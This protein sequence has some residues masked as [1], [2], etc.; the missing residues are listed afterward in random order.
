MELEIESLPKSRVKIKIKIK[1]EEFLNYKEKALEEFRNHIEI[2][3]FRKGKAPLDLIRK[4]IEP[5]QLDSKALEIAINDSLFLAIREKNLIPLENPKIKILKFSPS[6]PKEDFALEY[7]AEFDVLPE[8]KLGNWKQ[9]KIERP[10]A[11]VSPK[12]IEEVLSQIQKK[13]AIFV[14]VDREAKKGDRVEIDVEVLTKQFSPELISKLETKN[15]PL[16]IGEGFFFL[17][18]ENKLIGMKPNEEKEID[19]VFPLSLKDKELAG[20]EVKFKVKLKKLEEIKLPQLTDQFA[21]ELGYE[22]LEKLKEKIKET[23]LKEKQKEN[24]IE[25]ETELLKKIA[26]QADFEIPETLINQELDQLISDYRA[27]IEKAGFDF[28]KWLKNSATDL[29]KLKESF[30]STAIDRVKIALICGKITSEEG[31]KIDEKE[32]EKEYEEIK[33][34][35]EISKEQFRNYLLGKKTIE[36]IRK[37]IEKNS[38]N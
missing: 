10:Q 25:Y 36:F 8:I 17:D 37:T 12:E 6:A 38:A 18:F 30:R 33:N 14:P 24:E 28:E 20:K 31:I 29:T 19:F 27:Q 9:L 11:E 4:R 1:G 15:Q 32:L 2:N 26:D 5:N 3:G 34:E 16:V 7:E 23:L 13:K 21:K 22:N 35:R